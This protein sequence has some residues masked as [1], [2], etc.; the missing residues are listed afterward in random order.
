MKTTESIVLETT[1]EPAADLIRAGVWELSRGN[2]REAMETFTRAL[3]DDPLLGA[4][5]SARLHV[6]AR[7]PA[8]AQRVLTA[9]IERAPDLAEAHYLL[10]TVHRS[11]FR[12][13]EAMRCYRE[14]LRIDPEHERAAFELDVLYN[15]QEP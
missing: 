1:A 3:S 12:T 2:E 15:V 9:L 11:C 6:L 13:F 10:G 5:C 7:R 8:E 14:A 4:L